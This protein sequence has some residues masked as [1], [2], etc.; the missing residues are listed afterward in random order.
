MLQIAHIVDEYKN[1]ANEKKKRIKW[2]AI[3]IEICLQYAIGTIVILVA[4]LIAMIGFYRAL[5]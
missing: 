5:K 3:K 4:I 2:H 1:N